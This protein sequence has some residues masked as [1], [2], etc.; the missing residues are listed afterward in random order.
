MERDDAH[1]DDRADRVSA[2]DEFDDP[3]YEGDFGDEFIAEPPLDG[4][5]IEHL[6]SA[7]HE[8]LRAVRMVVDAADEFVETQRAAVTRRAQ[9]R[10]RAGEREPRVRRIDIDVA[11]GAESPGDRPSDA[12]G[13]FGTSPR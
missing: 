2:A 3:C 8:L 7:A 9:P 6:W 11:A 10:A 5:A 4:D 12:P 13:A 1:D